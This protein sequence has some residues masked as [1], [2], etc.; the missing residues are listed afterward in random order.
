M[1]GKIGWIIFAI[2]VFG[3]FS[4]VFYVDPKVRLVARG[5]GE[6]FIGLNFGVAMTF[7]AFFVQTGKFSWIPI[8]ASLPVAIL[9]SALLYINEFQDAKADAAVGKNHLVVRLGKKHAA[10]GYVCLILAT[11]LIIVIGV[12]TDTLPPITLVALLT[13]PFAFKAI[14]IT[15]ENYNDSEKLV[16]AN[17]STI[18]NHLLT[19]L[20]LTIGFF[21][22]KWI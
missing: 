12:V 5:I 18:M 14:K 16:P 6:L 3:V 15:Q 11:Y 22:D 19:G 8:I 21:I 13:I 9:I 10:L 1:D 7:G 4:A 17:I 2:G 20:L